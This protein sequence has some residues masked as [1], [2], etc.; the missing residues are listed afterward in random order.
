MYFVYVLESLKDK[1]FYKGITNNFKRRFRQHNL[2]KNQSTKGKK[3]YEL[4]YLEKV[5]DR[6]K[7]R[8]REKW[9][10]SSKGR[11]FLKKVIDNPR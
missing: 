5:E 4:V 11:E 8:E 9:L 3:P 10:K 6:R 2:G 7:A 1:S